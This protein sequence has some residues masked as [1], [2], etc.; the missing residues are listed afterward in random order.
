MG[1]WQDAGAKVVTCSGS[2]DYYD[3]DCN[4]LDYGPH[5]RRSR[6]LT[7]HRAEVD[8]REQP[9]AACECGWKGLAA[10]YAEHLDRVGAPVV[11]VYS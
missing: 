6:D 3:C 2:G 5:I 4:D 1:W 7:G 10:F 9:Y 11:A 8:L